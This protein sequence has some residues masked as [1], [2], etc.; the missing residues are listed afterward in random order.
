MITNL[1]ESSTFDLDIK[2]IIMS[3][4]NN[5]YIQYN[6]SLRTNPLGEAQLNQ[7]IDRLSPI[8]RDIYV[9]RQIPK[10]SVKLPEQGPFLSLGYLSTSIDFNIYLE[11][12]NTFERNTY[13]R[14]HVPKGR[15]AIYIPGHETELLFP[16]NIILTVLGHYKRS[17]NINEKLYYLDWYDMYMEPL[18]Y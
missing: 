4:I 14:I 1:L 8:D 5:N 9:M 10:G 18:N 2:Q 12:P 6:I 7:A 15:K 17:V 3:Y 16:H 13:L 11:E